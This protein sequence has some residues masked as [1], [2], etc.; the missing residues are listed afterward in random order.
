M[1][2]DEYQLIQS[3]EWANVDA[4]ITSLFCNYPP[5]SPYALMCKIT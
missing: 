2:S 3:Y 1:Q 4:I 5:P